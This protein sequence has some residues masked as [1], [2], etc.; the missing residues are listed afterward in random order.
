MRKLAIVAVVLALSGCAT[1]AKYE[2]LLDTWK[3]KNINELVES[4]GYPDNT[5]TA[6]NGNTVYVYGYHQSTYI[7]KTNYVSSGVGFDGGNL[8]S[9]ISI[10]SFGG[11]TV[12][13]NCSTYFE[14]DSGKT[15]IMW[16]WKGNACKTSIDVTESKK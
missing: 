11:Y 14:V 1:S 9:R 6:P 10:S 3:G 12:E 2:A 4:W 15:I 8:D 16:K 5:I 13:E 7:P